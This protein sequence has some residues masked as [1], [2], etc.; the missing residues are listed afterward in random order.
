M[1]RGSQRSNPST[2]DLK[3]GAHIK[4]VSLSRGESIN[5]YLNEVIILFP[6]GVVEL[7]VLFCNLSAGVHACK[8]KIRMSTDVITELTV[9]PQGLSDP[10]DKGQ[11]NQMPSVSWNLTNTRRNLRRSVVHPDHLLDTTR[12]CHR[13][14]W[15]SGQCPPTSSRR[16]PSTQRDSGWAWTNSISDYR[17]EGGSDHISPT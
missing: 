14:N 2:T 17:E 10:S 8:H 1:K 3:E 12:S 4:K 5:R 9:V 13:Q 6:N 7:S 11:P 15:E 16:E